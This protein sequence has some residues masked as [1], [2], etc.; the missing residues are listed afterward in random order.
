[1][2]LMAL[3][4]VIGEPRKGCPGRSRGVVSAH[5]GCP[6]KRDDLVHCLLVRSGS[7]GEPPLKLRQQSGVR[8]AWEEL[9]RIARALIILLFLFPRGFRL[10]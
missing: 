7:A 4:S 3:A 5:A 6:E 1:M 9:L 2:A 10:R 8:D